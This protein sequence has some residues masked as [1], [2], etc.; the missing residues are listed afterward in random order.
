MTHDLGSCVAGVG[1]AVLVASCGVLAFAAPPE[2]S[3]VLEGLAN[4]RSAAQLIEETRR[5]NSLE[6]Y[7]ILIA[8]VSVVCT[9]L[10]IFARF[11]RFVTVMET[12][13]DRLR[14]DLSKLHSQ[15]REHR[16]QNERACQELY[17]RLSH[18]E[19]R[20]DQTK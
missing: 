5:Q 8:V 15:T 4:S 19:G 6:F 13:A 2:P 3:A 14:E 7:A 16:A 1:A 9:G 10:G 12:N 11:T 18:L 20:F 17:Q